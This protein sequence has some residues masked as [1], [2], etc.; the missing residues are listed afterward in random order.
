MSQEELAELIGCSRKTISL[1]EASSERP[2]DARRIA[3]LLQIEEGLA[4]DKGVEFVFANERTGE[5]VR[6][7]RR[8][9]V[10]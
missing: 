7:R 1:I 4:R 10:T 6:L 2:S 9:S 5:G 8:R 3:V